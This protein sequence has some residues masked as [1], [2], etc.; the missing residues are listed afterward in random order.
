MS[1]GEQTSKQRKG[2]WH[3]QYPAL[4]LLS[5]FNA[6][7]FL[8]PTLQGFGVV[9]WR[10]YYYVVPIA[11]VEIFLWYL[12]L[13]WFGR[14]A[15][16]EITKA[17]ETLANKLVGERE[18]KEGLFLAKRVW[19]LLQDSGLLEWIVGYAER[20]YAKMHLKLDRLIQKLN[21]RRHLAMLILG[22]EPFI[23]G[24][25]FAGV[26]FCLKFKW[27]AGLLTLALGNLFH[28]AYML[29]LWKIIFYLF[30]K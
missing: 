13:A 4:T 24:G 15:V 3:W 18:V 9:G 22:A 29:G 14:V 7:S 12:L 5:I 30:K 1:N 26:L 10:L 28:I 8:I 2:W 16:P 17:R 27:P 20:I 21:H 6:D 25:R 11:T 23:A 19:K